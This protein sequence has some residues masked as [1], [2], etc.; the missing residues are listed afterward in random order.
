MWEMDFYASFY[1]FPSYPQSFYYQL[2]LEIIYIYL[3]LV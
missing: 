2:H 1:I 3:A